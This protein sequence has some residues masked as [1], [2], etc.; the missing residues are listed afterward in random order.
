MLDL[1]G[2]WAVTPADL[3]GEPEESK[4]DVGGLTGNYCEKIR[5]TLNTILG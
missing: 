1:E 3:E 2:L 5:R 4:G